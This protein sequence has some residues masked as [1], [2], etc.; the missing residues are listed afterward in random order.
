MQELKIKNVLN[1][2]L[3]PSRLSTMLRKVYARLFDVRSSLSKEENLE[4]IQSRCLEFSE[5]ASKIDPEL[6]KETEEVSQIIARK[7][8]DILSE[9]GIKLGGAGFYPA[10]YF[11]TRYTKPDCIVETGVAAGF[12]SYAFLYAIGKNRKGSLYSSDFPYFRI[13]NPEKYIGIVVDPALKSNWNL[14]IEGDVINLS[15]ISKKVEHIDIFHYDSDK[16]YSGRMNAL[17]IIG[18]KMDEASIILMDDI[19][20]NSH[21][22]DLVSRR[23]LN[24]CIFEF[25]SKYIG[26]IGKL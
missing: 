16:S 6:W 8:Q 13:S 24:Y 12:S 23:N 19:Q 22:H 1:Q 9:I 25:Q 7:S 11:I 18:G 15:K 26:L 10:L 14:Y 4:W 2:A 21:F 5:Y 17:S 3:K 20:N